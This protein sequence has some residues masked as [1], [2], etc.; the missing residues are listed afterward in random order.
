MAEISSARSW[1]AAARLT[2]G[3]VIGRELLMI[4][5][6]TGAHDI[7]N[8]G[9]GA[10]AIATRPEASGEPVVRDGR[11]VDHRLLRTRA[12]QRDPA[13][14]PHVHSVVMLGGVDGVR[15]ALRPSDY[16]PLSYV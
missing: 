9:T 10:V 3:A 16:S 15:H 4:T 6:I 8:H 14:R 1:A 12:G 13:A 5:R 2:E 11:R 7:V